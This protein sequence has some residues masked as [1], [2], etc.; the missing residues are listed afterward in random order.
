M[1][2]TTHVQSVSSKERPGYTE[3]YQAQIGPYLQKQHLIIRS[4]HWL[5]Q[6][7]AFLCLA[8]AIILFVVAMYYTFVWA[9]TGEATLLDDSWVNFGLSM[10]FLVFPWGLDSMLLRVFPAVIFPIAWYHSSK[11]TQY[12]TGIG[13]FLAGL[14]ITCAGAPGAAHFFGLASQALQNLF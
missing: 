4:L 10:S 14:G 6:V 1:K 2:S 13:A 8:L 3:Q 12:I 9:F 5:L 7:L 11:P